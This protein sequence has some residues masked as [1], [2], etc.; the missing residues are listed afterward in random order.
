MYAFYTVD[1]R[2]RTDI[3]CM[4]TMPYIVS[5]YFY[6]ISASHRENPGESMRGRGG[7]FLFS[8]Q[9]TPKDTFPGCA[10]FCRNVYQTSPPYTF[11]MQAHFTI[12]PRN[13][14]ILKSPRNAIF[15]LTFI[16]CVPR[17]I[18]ACNFPRNTLVF[19]ALSLP[20]PIVFARQRNR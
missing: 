15:R 8:F 17:S 20:P 4:F 12:F 11:Y 2:Y 16:A 7:H 3:P 13:I 6:D 10:H 14:V 5:N 18:S 19:A 1:S 9:Y